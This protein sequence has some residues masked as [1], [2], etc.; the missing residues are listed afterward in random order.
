MRAPF[1]P[2]ASGQPLQ[3]S[4]TEYNAFIK[5]ALRKENGNLRV[6]NP[7]NFG[8]HVGATIQIQNVSTADPV[9]FEKGD[10]VK[11]VDEFRDPNHDAPVNSGKELV[12]RCFTADVPE[13]DDPLNTV[14]A[15]CLEFIDGEYTRSVI[16]PDDT[17]VLGKIGHAIVDEIAVATVDV[18]DTSHRYA[19]PNGK[20]LDSTSDPMAPY[21]ILGSAPSATVLDL[22]VWQKGI[23]TVVRKGTITEPGGIS[24][25]GSGEVTIDIA[26]ANEQWNGDDHVVTAYLDWIHGGQDISEALAVFVAYFPEDDKWRIIA[27]DCEP[28]EAAPG[29][30]GDDITAE[31]GG[32]QGDVPLSFRVNQ[33]TVV[34]SDYDVV[35]LP[36]ASTGEDVFIKNSDA[37]HILRIYPAIGDSINDGAV[38][39]YED[40]S[41]AASVHYFA[42]T[43]VKWISA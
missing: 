32:V 18:K 5:T 3:I 25:G 13:A 11:I 14:Y 37:T 26:G 35:T 20:T 43:T 28:A 36:P 33:V 15:I 1:S 39:A 38:N 40:L 12:P 41:S 34:A 23:S 4:A 2:V 24:A 31:P 30:D 7:P 22:H 17:L 8:N 16:S 21:I 29:G 27:A 10:V 6:L 9:D 42:V 19:R